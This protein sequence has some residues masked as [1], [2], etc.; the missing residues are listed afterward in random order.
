MTDS[1]ASYLTQRAAVLGLTSTALCSAAGISRQTLHT[2][3]HASDKLPAMQT[4]LALANALP[5]HPIR[6]MQ[7][8]CDDH[9]ALFSPP[10]RKRLQGDASAFVRDVTYP[11]GEFVLP[12]QRFTKTREVQNVGHVVWDGRLLQCLDEEIVVYSRC[13]KT[14][15]RAQGL[16]PAAPCIAIPTTQPGELVQLRV[17]FTAPLLPGTVLSYWKTIFADGTPSFPDA[18]GL[19]VKVVIISM[20][21]AA[22]G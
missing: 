19:W 17:E 5:V 18:A 11:D 8:L 10:R 4:M 16:Q 21:A 9:P 6:L 22:I 13:G 12:G 14:L 20:D 1:L 7:L 15:H 2:L 3:L